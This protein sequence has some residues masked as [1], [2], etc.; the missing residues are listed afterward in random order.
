MSATSSDT[1]DEP[2]AGH[3]RRRHA[4]V[5]GAAAVAALGG[6]LFGYD[7]G[8]IAGALIFVQPDFG[9]SNLQAEVVT[10]ILLVGAVLGALVAG[11]AADAVGR[12]TTVLVTAAT[13]A[14][15]VVGAAASPGFWVLVASRLVIG[16]AVGSASMVVPLYISEIAPPARRGALTS[17]NQLAI[18]SGI[19]GS[20]IVAYALG[21]A[22]AWRWMFGLALVPA[23]VLFV[24]TLFLDDS[25]GYLL[26]KGRPEEAREVLQGLR[27]ADADIDAELEEMAE[28]AEKDHGL[29]AVLAPAV[30]PALVVGGALA[31]LQQVT[32][33][34]T[35]IYY[36]PTLLKNAGLGS[37]ASLLANVGV[38]AVNVGLTV[39]AILLLDRVGRRRLLLTGTAGMVLGLCG[40]GVAF[41]GGGD[42]AGP[43]LYLALFS[44]A[45]YVGSFAIGLGPVF[46]LLISEIYPLTVRGQAMSVAS[47]LNWGANFVVALT[48]LSILD[49]VGR[50]A[51]F[52]GY[53]AISVGALW[54]FARR[55]PETR[56]RTLAAIEKD[57]DAGLAA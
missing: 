12:R 7:T 46:W 23:A 26:A 34:N 36:A 41:L 32:G 42:L 21:S 25:P 49:A 9:L 51:T 19:L 47:M 24:G 29:R 31:V 22:E 14:V 6:L 57:L 30:R 40:M 43:A 52:F 35:V 4:G 16:L 44:L 48:F 3:G 5:R 37:Q 2:R 54:F 13:F 55:V 8:V 38:G 20:Q 45:F 33:I 10:S 28:L 18:T 1:Q 17:L 27:G 50:S 56:G 15:G 39:V 11:R 53:A